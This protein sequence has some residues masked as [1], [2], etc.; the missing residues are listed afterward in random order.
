SRCVP[1]WSSSTPSTRGGGSSSCC[2]TS[3]ATTRTA[4]SSANG[5]NGSARGC[6][7]TSSALP[8]APERIYRIGLW[9]KGLNGVLEL[10]GGAA[11]LFVPARV[12][13]HVVSVLSRHHLGHDARDRFFM[14]LGR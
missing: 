13:D 1:A 14:L 7:S 11:L 6:M 10:V 12:F 9:I 4:S 8:D 3:A 2:S 5:W